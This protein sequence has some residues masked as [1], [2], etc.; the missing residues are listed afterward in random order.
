LYCTNFAAAIETA[1]HHLK[2]YGEVVTVERWQGYPTK[3]KPDLV[4]KELMNVSLDIPM[5][6]D[7]DTLRQEI[8]PN[9]PWAD[10]HFRERVSG[11]A[12]NPDV[13]YEQWPWGEAAQAA[14]TAS[15]G[16]QFSHTYSERFWPR[17]AGA[18]GDDYLYDVR[19][20]I[21][22]EYGDLTSVIAL[23]HKE[24]YTRQAYLPIFFPEDTGAR[25]GGRIPCTLGY[26]FLLRYNQFHMWYFI[27]SCD[28]VRHFRDDL[29]LAVRLLLWMLEQQREAE[30]LTKLPPR[31]RDVGPGMLHFVCCSLHVHRGDEHRL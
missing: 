9:L 17:R 10:L 25:H 8:K 26:H 18:K 12:T 6:S 27:R 7:L 3:G 20:G 23:L 31:W 21:R 5:K 14:L 4:T 28:A 16:T 29:Y 11:I 13:S 24:P 2:S 15:A 1:I 30:R 19:R 22:Y